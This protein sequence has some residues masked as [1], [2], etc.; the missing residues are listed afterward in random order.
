MKGLVKVKS[1]NQAKVQNSY[2][3]GQN[4]SHIFVYLLQL[5]LFCF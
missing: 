5:L 1:Y 4:V 2:S 3:L